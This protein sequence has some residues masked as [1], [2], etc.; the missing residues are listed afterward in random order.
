LTK[1][2]QLKNGSRLA[3]RTDSYNQGLVFSNRPLASK[4]LFEVTLVTLD[5]KWTAS[6]MIGVTLQS[7]D[8]IHVPVT[9]LAL[10]KGAYIIAGSLVYHNG[11]KIS[12]HFLPDL[13]GL[14]SGQKVG[15]SVVNG[16]LHLYIN[17]IDQGAVVQLPLS[18]S[19]YAVVDL[20][21]QCTEISLVSDIIKLLSSLSLML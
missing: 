2:F 3:T 18:G 4:E 9:S 7:P 6:L 10:K 12:G 17:G 8:R 13:D 15:I 11:S 14:Q 20:Y 16:E 19:F 1:Y 21:G 5:P